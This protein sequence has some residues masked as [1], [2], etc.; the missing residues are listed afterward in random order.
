MPAGSGKAERRQVDDLARF[1][2]AAVDVRQQLAQAPAARAV[3]HA[4][5]RARP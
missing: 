2:D 1:G 4:R 3:R 5:T